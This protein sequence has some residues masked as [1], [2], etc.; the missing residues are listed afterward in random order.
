[1]V[2]PKVMADT[3]AEVGA[4]YGA[5]RKKRVVVRGVGRRRGALDRD[6][7]RAAR[8]CWG[9]RGRGRWPSSAVAARGNIVRS[10]RQRDDDGAAARSAWR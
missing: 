10:V 2:A 7:G 1:M 9:G 5:E 3:G 6:R 8:G 4:G